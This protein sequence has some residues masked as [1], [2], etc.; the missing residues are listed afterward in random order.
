MSK[1]QDQLFLKEAIRIGDQLLETAIKGNGTLHWK[2]ISMDASRK[3]EWVVAENSYSGVAGIALFFLELHKHTGTKKYLD[4][5][6]ASFN[7]LEQHCSKNSPFSYAFYT[8]RMSVSMSFLRLY[9]YTQNST[10]LQIA[11]RLAKDC[12]DFL[13]VPHRIDDLI[14]G[15]S[16]TLLGL[17]HLHAASGEAWILEDIQAFL[18]ELMARAQV[19]KK[20]LYW[21]RSQNQ[22]CGLCG[23]SHGAAGLGYVFMEIGHYF[24][25][26][27]F[28]ELGEQ[29]FTYERAKFRKDYQNWPDFRNGYFTEEDMIRAKAKYKEGDL[30]YFTRSSDMNA[31][32]HGAAG[33]GLS[34]LRAHQISLHS[35]YKKEA[36]IAIAKT[37]KTELANT[38]LASRSFT[39]CHGSGGNSDLFIEAALQWKQAN[40]LNL[41]RKVAQSAIE[42]RTQHGRYYSGFST[43]EQPE[44]TSLFMGNAGVGYFYLRCIDPQITQSVLAPQLQAVCTLQ[45]HPFD[46]QQYTSIR[47]KR[48]LIAKHYPR[49]LAIVDNLFPKES[50]TTLQENSTSNSITSFEKLVRSLL[51]S[52]TGQ[53]RKVLKDCFS[54]ERQK[55]VLDLSVESSSLL[56]LEQKLREESTGN[57]LGKHR[58]LQE[59]TALILAKDAQLRLQKYHWKQENIL[60]NLHS[61][62]DHYPLLLRSFTEGVLE[63][64]LSVFSYTVLE[65]F[66]EKRTVAQAVQALMPLFSPETKVQEEQVKQ[67]IFQ[68]LNNAFSG[69]VLELAE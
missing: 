48:F 69:G 45:K 32:C 20:G 47:I 34:R 13:G 22:V 11:L 29:A 64:E 19:S 36:L 33:I 17:L 5:T 25:N 54:L 40:Y 53:N 52:S 26:P 15:Y 12:K 44:D 57:Y 3:V 50:K 38:A 8:G 43:P 51:K 4:A 30:S 63:E 68:Q 24:N 35:I 2:S 59:K 21:D 61:Q 14:N 62:S 58:E 42:H 7:W 49:S 27:A 46:Q 16:G 56:F 23:F 67:A 18:D 9:E 41:A 60:Q 65:R 1:K 37:K 31:W 55:R 10:Y 28:Y 6:L 66:T 39:L